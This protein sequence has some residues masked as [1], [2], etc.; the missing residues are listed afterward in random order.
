MNAQRSRAAFRALVVALGVASLALF[1]ISARDSERFVGRTSPGFLAFPNGFVF[2]PTLAPD[3]G[4]ARRAGLDM[5]DLVVAVDGAPIHDAGD[6]WAAAERAGPGATL[7]YAV[8]KP[9]GARAAARIETRTFSARDRT[10]LQL[11]EV[12]VGIALLAAGAVPAWLR[13]DAAGARVLFVFC[14]AISTQ[15]CFLGLDHLLARRF[16]PWS[17]ALGALAIGASLHLAG[18]FP[19]PRW[20]FSTHRRAALAFFYGVPALLLVPYWIL[21]AREPASTYPFDLAAGQ[22]YVASLLWFAANLATTAL[23]A[24]DALDRQRARVVLLAPA[25]G[26]AASLGVGFASDWTLREIA[27]G[28]FSLSSSALPLA[29]GYAIAKRNLFAFDVVARRA[30][31]LGGAGAVAALACLALVAGLQ[32][33]LGTETAWTSAGVALIA[34]AALV[35]AVQP[36]RR[37]LEGLVAGVVFPLHRDAAA[38]LRGAGRALASLR[39]PDEVAELLCDAAT[40]SM[41][42]RALVALRGPEGALHLAPAAVSGERAQLAERMLDFDTTIDLDARPD[43]RERGREVLERAGAR[44][45]VPLPRTEGGGSG[46]LILD[47][48]GDGRLYTRDDETLLEALAAHSA[49]ALENAFAWEAVRAAQQHLAAEN[50]WLRQA[51]RREPAFDAIVGRSEPMQ[52][53][54]ASIEQVAPS[55]ARCWCSARRGTG[56]ELVADALHA[57]SPRRDARSWRSPAP[58]FRSRSSRASSSGTRRAPSPTPWCA[59]PVASKPRTAARSSSTTS[60]RCRPRCR[61]S[62]CARSSSARCSALGARSRSWSTCASSPPAIATCAAKCAP[63]VSAR[64]STTGSTWCRCRCRRCAS[65]A[66]TSRCSRSTSHRRAGEARRRGRPI[67][68]AARTPGGHAW[69]GN[70][71]ELRNTIERAV[72]LSAGAEIEV[73]ELGPATSVPDT[74]A[75]EP[76]TRG[77]AGSLAERLRVLKTALIEEAMAAAGGHQR[78]AAERLGLHRQSLARMMREL[79]MRDPADGG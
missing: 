69:S 18:S 45:F 44:L 48:R 68:A 2:E 41:R 42:A 53:L 39:A 27:I 78:R 8:R 21:F 3:P 74:A 20:P 30:L 31:A 46:G 58:R 32:R 17:Q 64:T 79:G 28:A 16:S 70:V 43:P 24:P 61:R 26:V 63:A 54:L 55:D 36:L 62:C 75:S 37:R 51:A 19:T 38:V 22:A 10:R 23:R 13:P 71:R 49:V 15:F 4:D 33:L 25:A 47:A 12:A 73:G 7:D 72:V 40:R 76:P 14:W 11:L 6:L 67:A 59:R 66:R 56:K 50:L 52:R 60:T 1:A 5:L 34:I 65:G 35:P 29:I 9:S 77:A 57:L